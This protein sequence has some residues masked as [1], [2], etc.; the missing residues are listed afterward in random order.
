MDVLVSPASPL[1]AIKVF[2]VKARVLSSLVLRIEA[3]RMAA[4]EAAIMA[5]SL[6]VIP[7]RTSL[8]DCV[9]CCTD[10]KLDPEQGTTYIL[11]VVYVVKVWCLCRA[12]KIGSAF[13]KL[14]A[15][16][17]TKY[18]S[19]VRFGYIAEAVCTSCQLMRLQR[20]PSRSR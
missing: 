18:M 5:K 2:L 16:A 3:P 19:V 6:P 13:E 11:A 17:E 10:V 12:S 14:C 20:R 15:V 4:F 9:S 1:K 8:H 7:R